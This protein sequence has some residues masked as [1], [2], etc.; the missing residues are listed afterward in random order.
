MGCSQVDSGTVV[1]CRICGKTLSNDV[2][3]MT[4]PFWDAS[5]TR[6]NREQSYCQSCGDQMVPYAVHFR[7]TRC[8]NEY[9]SNTEVAPRRDEKH[10]EYRTEGYC[11]RGCEVGASVERTVD[12]AS[13]KVGEVGGRVMGGI[14]KGIQ[15]TIR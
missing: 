10:D 5:K 9:A 14:I 15:K 3:Q 13:E 7:C 4:V 2:H 12:H 6:V 11:S 1:T 8:G